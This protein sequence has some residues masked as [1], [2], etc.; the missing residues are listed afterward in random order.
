MSQTNVNFNSNLDT[1]QALAQQARQWSEDYASLYPHHYSKQLDGMCAISSSYLSRLL[2]DN[3][4]AHKIAIYHGDD[5][6]HCF[7]VSPTHVIDI[8][9]T[10]YRQ[11]DLG[12]VTIEELQHVNLDKHAFWNITQ[13]FDDYHSLLKFQKKHGW[14]EE[15]TIEASPTLTQLFD[16]QKKKSPYYR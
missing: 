2:T 13:V 15:H 1:I 7:V 12:K 4:I 16:I 14:C 3:D 8:T 6:G 5:W 10:Q 11:F 9:A